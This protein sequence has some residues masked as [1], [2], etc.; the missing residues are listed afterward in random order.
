MTKEEFIL[1]EISTLTL[2]GGLSTRNRNYPIYSICTEKDRY[3]IN[4]YLRRQL[5][6]IYQTYKNNSIREDELMKL[7]ESFASDASSNFGNVL[8]KN[9]LRI[10]VSQKIINLFF[11]YLWCLGLIEEPPHCPFDSVIKKHLND[12]SLVDWT[13][14][15]NIDD[16]KKYVAITRMKANDRGISIA[17]WELDCWGA[18]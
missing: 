9:K 13:A 14:L 6:E 15:D 18:Y 3:N 12:N 8:F 7:I 11:K 17:Q 10:G 2:N 5:K 1:N 16:Y 4:K